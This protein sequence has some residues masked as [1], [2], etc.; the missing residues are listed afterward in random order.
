ME[1]YSEQSRDLLPKSEHRMLDGEQGKRGPKST[2]FTWTNTA[3][4]VIVSLLSYIAFRVTFPRHSECACQPSASF[5]GNYISGT[6]KNIYS[7]RMRR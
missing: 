7:M 3:L 5:D 4:L 1:D 2:I 6:A